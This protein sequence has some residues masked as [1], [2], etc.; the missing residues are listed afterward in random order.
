ME[1]LQKVT[2]YDLLGYTVPGTIL[3]G[4]IEMCFFY[5]QLFGDEYKNYAGYICGATILLGYVAGMFI[6]ELTNVFLERRCIKKLF[7]NKE[8][9]N[10]I[11]Y[12]TILKALEKAGVMEQTSS[13]APEN[14]VVQ[15][16]QE[17]QVKKYYRYM[18]ADIQADSKYSR[19]HN[20][21]SSEL[22]CKNS[23]FVFLIS[24]I[25]I[26]GS[27]CESLEMGEGIGILIVGIAGTTLLFRRYLKQRDQKNAYTLDWFVQKHLGDIN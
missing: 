4:V 1:V 6:A 22:V 8:E 14:Q 25:L 5:S 19:I 16:N 9:L 21:A 15:I 3:V 20:Y 17:E 2:I 7:E 13:F 24:T 10:N 23:S 12:A 26:L 18:Y 27:Q 11:G